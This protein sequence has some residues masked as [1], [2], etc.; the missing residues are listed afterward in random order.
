[1][2]PIRETE[3]HMPFPGV[4]VG[5]MGA[6]LGYSS[7]DNGWLSFSNYRIPRTNHLSR[8]CEIDKEGDFDLKG[9]PRLIYR[10]MVSTRMLLIQ[11]AT[12]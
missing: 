2:V 4:E 6:K 8:F 12:L 9:D 1:M 5:D 3:T 11:G 7:M 10:I